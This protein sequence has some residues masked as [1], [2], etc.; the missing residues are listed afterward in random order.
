MAPLSLAIRTLHVLTMA[1][2]VGGTLAVWYSY[3]SGALSD[4]TLARRYEWGFWAAL[5]VVVVTGVGN[6][7]ALGA[8][9]PATAWG[10]TFLVKLLVVLAV[11]VGSA[12][13]TLAVV[14]ADDGG[15]RRTAQLQSVGRLY[16]VTTVSLLALVVLAEVLAHG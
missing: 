10:Q 9:G 6:L 4:L 13:R 16:G 7:G 15:R 5:G 12:V 1:V 3:R 14:R 8:P 2:L 11:V